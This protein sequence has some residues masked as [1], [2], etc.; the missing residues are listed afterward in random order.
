MNPFLIINFYMPRGFG[1][2]KLST[3]PNPFLI[4]S[5]CRHSSI[6]F[7]CSTSPVATSKTKRERIMFRLLLHLVTR[8]RKPASEGVTMEN[9]YVW[10]EDVM[11]RLRCETQIRSVGFRVSS[12]GVLVVLMS[13]YYLTVLWYSYSL[14]C[15]ETTCSMVRSL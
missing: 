1:Q 6:T 5:F 9:N 10:F 15:C 3:N 12:G 13:H 4:T 8:C 2:L 7:R 14:I 11:Q